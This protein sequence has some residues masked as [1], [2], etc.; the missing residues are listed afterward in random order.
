MTRTAAAHITSEMRSTERQDECARGPRARDKGRT[1]RRLLGIERSAC[2]R[3][4][5]AEEPPPRAP[6]RP[7][8][9]MSAASFGPGRPDVPSRS[10]LMSVSVAE[11]PHLTASMPNVSQAPCAGLPLLR[12]TVHSWIFRP[13]FSTNGTYN[14]GPHVSLTPHGM[15]IA[16]WHNCPKYEDS[17]GCEVLYSTSDDGETWN[18][19]RTLVEP[20]SA[21]VSA[22]ASGGP[23]SG[24]NVYAQG[25]VT[26]GDKRMYHLAGA[27]NLVCSA[28]CRAS[29]PPP[30]LEAC[31]ASCL[32]CCPCANKTK[33]PGIIGALRFDAS[34]RLTT[35][36][37]AW[38]ATR[39]ELARYSLTSSEKQ[40]PSY[41]ELGAAEEAMAADA[42]TFNAQY[43]G[44]HVPP[45]PPPARLSER[46]VYATAS[47]AVP[48]AELRLTSL[49]RDDGSPPTLTLWASFCKLRVANRTTASSIAHATANGQTLLSPTQCPAWS[50]P[51][52]TNIPDSR[53]ATWAGL[54]PTGDTCLL[55][56]QLP[57]LWKRDPLTLSLSSDGVNFD[58]LVAARCDAP[59]MRFP[60]HTKGPGWEYPSAVV[61]P[62][63]PTDARGKVQLL[64][65]YSV[66]KEDI[67]ATRV[68]LTSLPTPARAR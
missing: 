38:L 67:A 50:A 65:V 58:R 21:A 68:P 53:S 19:S 39:A 52:P 2:V 43:L 54:L 33:L 16:S 22:N 49:L 4:G 44:V 13:G 20:L 45:A 64:I 32:A 18:Q 60:A 7:R 12:D 55:G 14:H 63:R 41:D 37:L 59:P 8:V 6:T 28:K 26:L 66:N 46:S 1:A 35:G 51:V 36:P 23:A 3:S 11:V 15:I 48:A 56:A 10:F 31:C 17:S 5:A 24:V 62:P 47:D 34:G 25:F 57:K 40:I 9:L 30:H 42:A 27:Y 61:L 29:P